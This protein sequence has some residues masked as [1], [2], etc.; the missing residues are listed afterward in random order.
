MD[1]NLIGED[2]RPGSNGDVKGD[3]TSLALAEIASYDS[4]RSPIPI[5]NSALLPLSSL[6]PEVFERLIAELV[7]R[8]HN[9]DAHFYGRRGQKQFGLDIVERR[10]DRS[11][12]LYQVKRYQTITSNDLRASVVEYAGAPRSQDDSPEKRKFDAKQFVLVTSAPFDNDTALVDGLDALQG[13]YRGDID[14]LAWGAEAISAKLRDVPTLVFAAF[15]KDWAKAFCGY[16]SEANA[17]SLPD[18]YGLVNGPITTLG[19]ATLEI[20]ATE[21]QEANPRESARLF[22]II[23]TKLEQGNFPSNAAGMKQRQA[24][25]LAQAGDLQASA[26]ISFDLGLK[27]V[28]SGDVLAPSQI[29]RLGKAS[30]GISSLQ[31]AKQNILVFLA[32]WYERGSN[33]SA[34]MP[35]L[36]ELVEVGDAH[37]PVLA[38]LTLEQAIVDG[39]YDFNP[40]FST[41]AKLDEESKD[42]AR[43]LR[44]LA[45]SCETTDAIYRARLGCAVADSVLLTNSTSEDVGVAYDELVEDALAGRFHQARGL[46]AS[47][48]ANAFAKSGDLERSENLWRQSILGSSENQYYG[49]SRNALHAL[50]LFAWETGNINIAEIDVA[51][52]ALPNRRRIIS[53]AFEPASSAFEYAH[54][55]KL[56]DALGD[57]RRYLFESRI[58]GHLQDEFLAEELLGDIFAAGGHLPA[59]IWTYVK[60]GKAD[61]AVELASE[62]REEVDVMAWAKSPLRRRRAAA[63][64]V[65]GS[66]AALVAD[67]E[68]EERVRVLLDN[69][70]GLWAT[71]IVSPRPEADA[72]K[73]I[74]QFGVRIPPSAVDEILEI[75]GPAL[76]QLTGIS[77]DVAN[78]LVQT[79]WSVENRRNDVAV[80]IGQMLQLPNPSYQIWALVQEVPESGREPLRPVVRALAESGNVYGVAALA[81]WGEPTDAVQLAARRA[82]AALL[83]QPV[84]VERRVFTIGTQESATVELLLALM[85]STVLTE[86]GP[87]ELSPEKARLPGGI[88]MQSGPV[89]SLPSAGLPVVEAVA[90]PA[91]DGEDGS[92]N[93]EIQVPDEAALAAAGPVESLVETIAEHFM[94]V[95]E[96]PLS[97]AG[98]RMQAIL[99][100]RRLLAH[101]SSS[102][103]LAQRL[104]NVFRNPEFTELDRIEMS[105][106]SGLG[107][108]Q[109]NTGSEDLPAYA[110]L[111]SAETL[112]TAISNGESDTVAGRQLISK[113]LAPALTLLRHEK[114]N[115]RRLG[116]LAC[117]ALSRSSEENSWISKC[118]VT[119]EDANVRAWG[120]ETMPADVEMFGE[121]VNDPAVEVRQ[122]LASRWKELPES[123]RQ[124]LRSDAHLAVRR[125]VPEEFGE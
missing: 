20:E 24:D 54:R 18:P 100:L 107:R 13:E 89:T 15:G 48:A 59:A 96:D 125:L 38:C 81:R 90:P 46:I 101:A 105:P 85:R 40:P 66:Q 114:A 118:L 35:S 56:P 116:G 84:G 34:T 121:F 47:R 115:V 16:E 69:T 71:T 33:L 82:A 11:T 9:L 21:D 67:L 45:H 37:A 64:Q 39:I 98:P 94:K 55:G 91:Q 4:T 30:S 14:V 17:L 62:L 72:V 86:C 110:L 26:E 102:I 25:A 36:R 92:E 108:F 27:R 95:A 93:A 31:N 2:R 10:M 99:A 63:V 123:L 70:A 42:L 5:Q 32:N 50:R 43:E 77:D 12:C 112:S 106:S 80:A 58:S 88:I 76:E 120:V 41:M 104:F 28:S 29:H 7:T 53:G 19:L 52:T 79:Y 113:I 117:V 8:Q 83:R 3:E 124:R 97:G 73:A 60:A 78:L 75:A 87:E 6:E 122:A 109:I 103:D 44:T 49:D 119:H 65:I 22:G 51:A 74:S 61:K 57:A 1:Q 111:V 23:S 68:V